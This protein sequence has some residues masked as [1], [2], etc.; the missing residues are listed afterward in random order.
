M[1]AYAIGTELPGTDLAARTNLALPIGTARTVADVNTV[2]EALRQ[3]L[4]SA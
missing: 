1:S 2:V 4:N 3:A